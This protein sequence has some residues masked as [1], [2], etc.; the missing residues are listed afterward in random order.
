MS[1]RFL[2]IADVHLGAKF[3]NLG[4]RGEAQRTQLLQAFDDAVNLAVRE[5][6]DMVLIA[7]DLFDSAD[8]SRSLVARVGYHMQDLGAV[9][10][11][12][13]VSPGTHDPYGE[14]SIWK[15]AELAR[16]ENLR[17]FESEQVMP[18]GVPELDCTIYGNANVRPFANK[19]PLAKFRPDDATRFRV[20][21]VH[22][23]FEI[24]D[25]TEDTYVVTS[26]NV[27]DCGLDYLAL[28]HYHSLSERSAGDTTAFYPGSLEM[29]RMQKGDCGYALLVEVDDEEVFVEPVR[30]GRR[31]YEELT[32][33][34]EDAA[35]A[36]LT[37][38]IESKADVDKVL[39]VTIEGVRR[40]GFPDMEALLGSV[41]QSF[42]HIIYTDRSRAAPSSLDAG[43]YPEGSAARLFLGILSE[44]MAQASES[45]KEELTD[46]MQ[47]GLTLLAEGGE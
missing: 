14:R 26:A 25:I 2:H 20:G 9:G 31:V 35:A 19:Y 29:V 1:L 23:S 8:V 13:F 27:R 21:M 47:L 4:R 7:G 6:V 24:P 42:F 36:G 46:A 28:G 5:R 34:A 3:L 30:I 22:A 17:I 15:T 44:R 12:V 40:A 45:E 39:H 16:A 41:A 11:P 10:I 37:S 32:I 18:M 43:T 38:L 33:K